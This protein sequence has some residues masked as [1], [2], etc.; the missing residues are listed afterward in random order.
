MSRFVP[1]P[2]N[3]AGARSIFA[4]ALGFRPW[5]FERPAGLRRQPAAIGVNMSTIGRTI[6][7]NR[8]DRRH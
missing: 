7:Q 4:T 2:G 8:D 6:R 3:A 5:P 1:G